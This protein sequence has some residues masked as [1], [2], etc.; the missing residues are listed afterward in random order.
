MS[1]YSDLFLVLTAVALNA[2][3]QLFLR[4]GMLGV[5]PSRI[6]TEGIF[7]TLKGAVS[8]SQVWSGL[9]CYAVSV[10]L[11]LA[12]LSRVEVGRAYPLQGFGYILV[13]VAGWWMLGETISLSQ[14]IGICVIWLG[15][16]LVLAQ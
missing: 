15:A 14:L 8:S 9:T 5:G 6:S 1:R 12:V 10:A 13:A 16:Y 2:C 11:W 3:A 7:A 4:K